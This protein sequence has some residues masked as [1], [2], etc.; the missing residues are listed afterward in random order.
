M[1]E[2]QYQERFWRRRRD[3]IGLDTA[4]KEF[5]AIEFKRTQDVKSDYVEQL[6]LL[7]SSMGVCCSLQPEYQVH[8]TAPKAKSIN[9]AAVPPEKVGASPK[10]GER[11]VQP[12][13]S[14]S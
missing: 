5:L 4:T 14:R 7:R 9:Q 12:I 6:Q 1:T 11:E 2:E 8:L 3:G 10:N 13:S